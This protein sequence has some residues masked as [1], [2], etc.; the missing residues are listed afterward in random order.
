M[1]ALPTNCHT[2]PAAPPR[3]PRHAA[4]S[5]RPLDEPA[6]PA[7]DAPPASRHQNDKGT[8]AASRRDNQLEH[9]PVTL[10]AQAV[11]GA[12]VKLQNESPPP[13]LRRR[14]ASP[15][16]PA[17]GGVQH[18]TRAPQLQCPVGFPLQAPL[19]GVSSTIVPIRLKPDRRRRRWRGETL[20]EGD[21]GCQLR[22]AGGPERRLE[23]R[24]NTPK[25]ILQK[26]PPK[27]LLRPSPSRRQTAG[28]G[29]EQ[30]FS[31]AGNGQTDYPGVLESG[32]PAA[33]CM[34]RLRA[35]A[36]RRAGSQAA[37][38][39]GSPSYRI[40]RIDQLKPPSF[41]NGIVH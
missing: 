8:R 29:S 28:E 13:E 19:L 31:T 27:L 24:E 10:D 38:R 33:G 41:G 34:A 32:K 5:N 6:V 7:T 12:P 18:S 17:I 37:R 22:I 3:Q 14:G 1:I 25:T 2:S 35:P 23:Y 11:A 4:A 16:S 15:P 30:P 9:N 39:F 21:P 20:H 36:D 40:G 26:P